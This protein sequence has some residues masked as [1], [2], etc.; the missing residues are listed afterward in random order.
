MTLTRRRCRDFWGSRL[1][2][3]RKRARDKVIEVGHFT[4]PHRRSHFFTSDMVFEL[5]L[6]TYYGCG[7]YT[8]DD[9]VL[10]WSNVPEEADAEPSAVCARAATWWPVVCV[11][12]RRER[13][14]VSGALVSVISIYQLLGFKLNAWWIRTA[15]TEGV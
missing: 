1:E 6:A 8:D 4:D 10:F 15:P 11:R 13:I 2:H 5:G 12:R 3:L 14:D 9:V 7:K